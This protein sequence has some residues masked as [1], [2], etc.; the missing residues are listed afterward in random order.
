LAEVVGEH[1]DLAQLRDI[2]ATAGPLTA[3]VSAKPSPGPT[4]RV[5]YFHDSAFTF[6]YPENLEALERAGAELVAV[7]SLSATRLPS[8]DLLYIGGGFPETHAA[9]LSD[10]HALRRAVRAAAADGLPIY[11][12]CGG[13]IYL[14]ESFRADG[15]DHPMSGVL[16]V[17]VEMHGRPQGHGYCDVTVDAPNPFYPVGTALRGHEFHYSRVSA[18]LDRVT[19]AY[20]VTRGTGCGNGRDGLV[21]GNVLASYAHLHASGTPE[22]AHHLCRCALRRRRTGSESDGCSE[23]GCQEGRQEEVRRWRCG[24]RGSGDFTPPSQVPA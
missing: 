5:G 21:V 18:G 9:K 20:A 7:S 14:S 3:D 22:W 13:L 1:V 12:E 16:P 8:L 23:E 2:A 15:R 19:S 17:S 24:C 10:N 4:L 6:Y 11:A